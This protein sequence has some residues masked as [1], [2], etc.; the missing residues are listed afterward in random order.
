MY[1]LNSGSVEV[2]TKKGFHAVLKQGDFF[3]EGA[4]LDLPRIPDA[5]VDMNLIISRC[6]GAL[7]GQDKLRSATVKC[8]TPIHVLEISREYFEKYLSSSGD[9]NLNLREKNA[10]RKRQRAQAIIRLQKNLEKRT[11]HEGDYVYKIGDKGQELFILEDGE[12][13]ILVEDQIV[14]TLKSGDTCGEHSLIFSRPRTASAICVSNQCQLLVMPAAE[15]DAFLK[16]SPMT[17]ETLRDIASRR[18]FQKA[19]VF[20]TKKAFPSDPEKLRE[21]FD[22]ADEDNSNDLTLDNVRSMLKRM[23]PA[24]TEKDVRIILNALDIDKSG[25]VNFEEF[26]R[27]L[28][29]SNSK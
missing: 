10:I 1:F 2:S 27:M 14:M 29:C 24:L 20:K 22:A 3:G 15:F 11:V 12:V 13:N 9:L 26:K 6:T 23:D 18:E 21:A 25:S 4:L 8:L 7:L 16:S 17:R 5:P 19:I 28:N